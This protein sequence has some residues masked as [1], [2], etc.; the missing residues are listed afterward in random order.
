MFVYCFFITIEVISE[1]EEHSKEETFF[2]CAIILTLPTFICLMFFF[3]SNYLAL[4]LDYWLISEG[5]Q[6]GYSYE[7][8]SA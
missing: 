4:I 8:M 2:Y 3:Y 5:D 6:Q 1:F 7:T